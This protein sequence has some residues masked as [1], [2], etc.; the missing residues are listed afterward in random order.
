MNIVSLLHNK[1]QIISLKKPLLGK[2]KVTFAA[3]SIPKEEVGEFNLDRWASYL[4]RALSLLPPKTISGK[5]KLI[6]GQNFWHFTQVEI[7]ADITDSALSGFLKQQLENKTSIKADNGYFHHVL[8]DFK[9][10][11]FAG[12]YFLTSKT[13]NELQTL[14]SFYDLKISEIYPEALLIYSLFEHTLNK[15]KEEAA[16][17]LEY[18][19]DLSSGL[20]FNSTGLISKKTI[21]I[22]S[23]ELIKK[24]KELNKEQSKPIARLI[25]GGKVS[26]KVRQDNFTKESGLWTNPLEKV[27]Q[28]SSLE[29]L[30]NK[31]G[32]Q[33]ELLP[34]CREIALVNLI[35]T[36]K[37]DNFLLNIKNASRVS[38]SL[39]KKPKFPK[40]P[41][42]T[43]TKVLILVLVSSV[44]TY[45]LINLGNWGYGKIKNTKVSSPTPTTKPK[46]KK[47]PTPALSRQELEIEI[48]N[49]TGVA[50]MA[51]S[52]QTELEDLGYQIKEIGN[53][54]NYDYS[55]TVIIAK[56]Q[57]VFRLIKKDLV[58]FNVSQPKFEQTNSE[59]TT[60]IFGA[61]LQLP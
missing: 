10:K 49:G 43:I 19:E 15:Q 1:I 21:A 26:T 20:L 6:L 11:K 33:K 61:D 29:P 47:T 39:P 53:A 38:F 31:L 12:V 50:G 37:Q 45:G 48:L 22:K 8:Y 17:F 25:L 24:L 13:F 5:A 54:E 2:K 42:K 27:L 56:N 34:L 9:G 32:L 46:P 30:A 23:E 44:L 36:K 59:I 58:E 51:S 16:L 52:L 28:N 18:E 35:Q 55:Q 14:L 57:S 41:L 7:P 40:L 3:A 60:I 4:K